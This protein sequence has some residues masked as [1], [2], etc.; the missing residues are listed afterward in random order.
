MYGG[1]LLE[2]WGFNWAFSLLGGGLYSGTSFFF[3]LEEFYDAIRHSKDFAT[4]V[5]YPGTY[6]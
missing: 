1:V 5:F 4:V 3:F 6:Y 2:L